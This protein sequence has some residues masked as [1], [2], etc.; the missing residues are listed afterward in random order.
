MLIC[1]KCGRQLNDGTRF[2]PSCGTAISRMAAPAPQAPV[3]RAQDNPAASNPAPAYQAPT[4][5]APANPAP[6]YQAPAYQPLVNPAPAYQAPVNP[7]PVYPAPT[8]QPPVNAAPAAQPDCPKKKSPKK[9]LLFGAIGLAVVAA[10][11]VAAILLFGGS[12]SKNK[13]S[14]ALYGKD[15]EI[16]FSNLKNDP[17]QL[18]SRLIDVSGVSD[19]SL[20]NMADEYGYAACMSNDGKYIFF[21]DKISQ[22]GNGLY[23]K[24]ASNPD[25]DAVKID[26]D[27]YAYYVGGSAKYVTYLKDDA[28]YQYD[29]GADS[30]NKIA[31]DAGNGFQVSEDGK[32]IVYLTSDYAVYLY[33]GEDKEKIASDVTIRYIDDKLTVIYYDKDNALYRQELPGGEKEKLLSDVT[34]VLNFY[35]SGEVYFVKGEG[36]DY[37]ADDYDPSKT[38][39]SLCYYDGEEITELTDTFDRYSYNYA[40]EAAVITYEAYDGDK[41]ETYVAVKGNATVLKQEKEV[42]YLRINPAGTLVYYIDDIAD[43]KEEGTLYR[44][45]ISGE[46]VGKPEV[47][48]DDVYAGRCYFINDDDFYYFKDYKD[49]KGELYINK[50]KVDDDVRASGISAPFELGKVFYYTDWSDGKGTLKVYDGEEAVKISDDVSVF[51]VVPN[52]RALYLYDYSARSHT[53]ELYLWN[54]GNAEKLDEDVFCLIP[55]NDAEIRFIDLD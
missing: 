36:P 20:Y 39:Y 8:Y 21:V 35:E 49:G 4:Y 7:A 9:A 10:A 38:G 48:D 29:I 42:S 15:R 37:S 33:D 50:N 19:E 25:A 43:D 55:Y 3:T 5:Q 47:Y 24:S 6:T 17:W 12:G 1:P 31:N 45:E 14:F 34:T 18:T 13:S 16:Y 46:E 32:K 40:S 30:K 2:C 53:G 27:V 22:S 44:I 52:G 51:S 54:D 41:L 23:Y 28:L 26:S 11:V